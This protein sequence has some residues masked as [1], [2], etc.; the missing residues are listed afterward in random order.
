MFNL[1]I[2]HDVYYMV[3]AIIMAV[4]M[5]TLIPRK[6]IKNLFGLCIFWGYF[7]SF[8]FIQL[9]APSLFDLFVWEQTAFTFLG[10]PLLINI[11][12]VPAMMIFLYFKPETK[13]LY[14][15]YILSLSFISGGIDSVFEQ[16]GILHYI[17]WSPIARSVVALVWFLAAT[18]H[19]NY[20]YHG[21]WKVF[22]PERKL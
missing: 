11:S 5:L 20:V 19:Y 4:F 7:V 16:L 21:E 2:P 10:S 6:E 17:Y 8:V 18:C 3:F 1:K 15:L 9:F 13:H 22:A 14:W 12:W